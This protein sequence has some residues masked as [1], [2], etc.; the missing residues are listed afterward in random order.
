MIHKLYITNIYN[1]LH[2]YVGKRSE[3]LYVLYFKQKNGIYLK[4]SKIKENANLKEFV[5]ILLF[6]QALF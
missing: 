1:F 3:V 2:I 5:N 6:Y 4:K